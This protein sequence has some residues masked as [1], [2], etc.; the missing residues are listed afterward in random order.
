MAVYWWVAIAILLSQ[1]V[2]AALLTVPSHDHEQCIRCDGLG[3]LGTA[4][5]LA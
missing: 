4:R 3:R 2:R 5:G 1:P